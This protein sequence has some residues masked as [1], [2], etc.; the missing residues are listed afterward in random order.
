MI[1]N[2]LAIAILLLTFSFESVAQNCDG[3]RY[4][5]QIFTIVDVTEV[6]YTTANNTNLKMDIYQPQ[7]DVAVNRPLIVLA[8]GG[9][10]VGGSKT[11]DNVVVAL[12]QNFA[13]RGYVTASINYRLGNPLNM[14]TTNGA[15]EVVMKAISDGKAA[16]RYFRKDVA[17]N[18]NTFKINP[19]LIFIGGNSAGAVLAMH[20]AYISSVSETPQNIQTIMNANGG[21]E[22]NSGNAGYS[23]AIS[24]VINLAGGLNQ[25]DFINNGEP[26]VIS[27]HGSTDNVVPYNCANAQ[28]GATP[29]ILCG[30]GAMQPR[31]T[32]EEIVHVSKVYQGLGHTPW[33]TNST[34]MAEIDSMVSSFLYDY[35]CDGSVSIEEKISETQISVYPN[36]T[37][38]TLNIKSEK[39]FEKI[40]VFDFMGRKVFEDLATSNYLTINTSSFRSGAYLMRVSVS[41]NV[42]ASK[43]IIIE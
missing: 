43:R 14:L 27:F 33:Q 10:F 37:R 3:Q 29:V 12:C 36:P 20:Y 15:I 35:A 31:L 26:P 17:E 9:S 5:D 11:Q 30:L 6:T 40:E 18:G 41:G 7:G 28:G 1:K 2:F 16:V 8:H 4:R 38:N 34:M 39:Y 13:K 24:G 23:S 21:I 22:G 42:L 19:D 32:S 25:V